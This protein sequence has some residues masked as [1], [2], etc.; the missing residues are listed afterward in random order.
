MPSQESASAGGASKALRRSFARLFALLA[1]AA[2]LAQPLAFPGAEGFGRFA[3]G[4]RGGAVYAVTNL[5]DS[6]TGSLRDAVSAG[7]R[8]VVFR[9]SGTIELQSDLVVRHSN[10]TIAG[11]TAPG[12]GICLK[13][14]PLKLNGANHVIIRHL[15]VR[16]GAGSGK[17]DD[18]IGRAHV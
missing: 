6:G 18:E 8:T 13:N 7:N 2:A 10:L 14:F 15:R 5:D 17:P 4:G 9:V 1:P 12:D 3:T 16:P 11:Q